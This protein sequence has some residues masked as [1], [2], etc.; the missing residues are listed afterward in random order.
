MATPI[1]WAQEV[2]TCD[3]CNNAAYQFC[4][5]C[6]VNLCGN[7]I[8]K[9][10]DAHKLLPHDIVPFTKRNVKEVSQQCELHP[11]QKCEACC[12][13]CDVV[14]CMKCV[15]TSHKTHS[16]E[17]IPA[18]YY[19]NIEKILL[20]SEELQKQLDF[21]K[22]QSA[23]DKSNT[24]IAKTTA[25]FEEIERELEGHQICWHQEVDKIFEKHQ[26][27]IKSMKDK[28]IK[29]LTEKNHESRSITESMIQTIKE[30]KEILR[31][32]PVSKVVNYKSKLQEYKPTPEGIN[33]TIPSLKV[34]KDRGKELSIELGEFKA[35]LTQ[36]LLLGIIKD[37][38]VLSASEL[39]GKGRVIADIQHLPKC[40]YFHT[41]ACAGSDEAWIEVGCELIL[42]LDIRGSVKESISISKD[43]ADISV[44]K[45]GELIYTEFF[46][47]NVNIVRR[48]ITKPLIKAPEGWKPWGLCCTDSGN[49]LVD[50]ISD[51]AIYDHKIVCYAGQKTKQEIQND[52]KGV[53][54]FRRGDF[55]IYLAKNR[56]G[57]ICA[58]DG[59]A[60]KVVV[61]DAK[62]NVR[63]RYHGY[64]ANKKKYFCPEQIATDSMSQIIVTDHN[65]D[66]LHILDR[67]GQF[68]QCV[69]DCGLDTPGGLSVD[70]KGRCW[71]GLRF[72]K[73]KVI[74]LKM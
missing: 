59:N 30:N 44:T 22:R 67:N 28:A 25:K 51:D 71:V 34:K 23:A 5:S 18:D 7:C 17:E 53:P 6:Q 52:S 11:G 49:I 63:F 36:T 1:T 12:Q 73:L 16:I 47:K 55:V 50:L 45:E 38:P 35:T 31:S 37:V 15:I 21:E 42:R 2:I 13:Q 41:I 69:D 20:E 4:N 58:S 48:N 32:K 70:S 66:C 39:L 10:V 19:D 40:E 26:N 57:D 68:L 33:V 62:G 27:S 46:G 74:S 29:S 54:I 3:I 56:N 9:H 61:M 8:N 60:K 65:N 24:C 14:V 43:L 72:G 64:E